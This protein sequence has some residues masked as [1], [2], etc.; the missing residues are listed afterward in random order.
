MSEKNKQLIRQLRSAET[1]LMCDK[2]TFSE[3]GELCNRSADKI[4]SLLKIISELKGE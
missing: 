4:E 1:D 3:L 2:I